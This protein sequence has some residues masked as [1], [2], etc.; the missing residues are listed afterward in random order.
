MH[1]ISIL[2]YFSVY[3]SLCVENHLTK[4]MDQSEKLKLRMSKCSNSFSSTL[5]LIL[6]AAELFQWPGVFGFVIGYFVFKPELYLKRILVVVGECLLF[7]DDLRALLSAAPQNS[8][9]VVSI[10]HCSIW[11]WSETWN[12]LRWVGSWWSWGFK[13]AFAQST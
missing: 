3:A 5:E 7:W 2:Q 1:W 9:L 6:H 11:K 10:P 13:G 4:C 12:Y 8:L